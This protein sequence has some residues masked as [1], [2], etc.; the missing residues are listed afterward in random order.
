LIDLKTRAVAR[1]FPDAHTFHNIYKFLQL[2]KIYDLADNAPLSAVKHHKIKLKLL[3]DD[4]R[5]TFLSIFYNLIY[6]QVEMF[7]LGL[8]I[9]MSLNSK[10]Y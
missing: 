1:F 6:D 9:F 10:E 4:L 2:T 3:T 8:F 5:K 7:F